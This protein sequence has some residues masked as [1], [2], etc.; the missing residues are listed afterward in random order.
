MKTTKRSILFAL[1]T[2]GAALALAA[3][4]ALAQ[5]SHGDDK[6]AQPG[7]KDD[8]HSHGPAA[9]APDTYA[10]AVA[11]MAS[12]AKE[13]EE[14]LNKGD[15]DAAHDEGD[16]IAAIARSLGALALK[17]D[18]GVDK[19]KVKEINNAGKRI[20]FLKGPVTRVVS[21]RSLLAVHI[22]AGMLGPILGVLHSG[23]RFES[24]LGIALTA[25]MLIVAVSG[26]VGRYLMGRLSTDTR[27]QQQMLAGM[28][29]AYERTAG[30]LAKEPDAAAALRP[31]AG[32]FSRLAAPFFVADPAAG[33][34]RPPG[35]RERAI[36]LS[37][38]MADLEY[39]IKSHEVV[40]D[41]FGRWLACH[42]VIAIV[43]YALLAIH[44]WSAWYFGIRW[45]P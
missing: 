8:G 24:P 19:A 14:A 43:L 45:L 1:F 13:V 38:S 11:E 21:M 7:H 12:R 16:A 23:H 29:V 33:A 10:K 42:I 44:V 37:E 39:A 17:P 26:F 22:Y 3:P 40:K 30:E 25:M 18:S 27:E 41:A 31:F 5:H 20:P 15:L 36:R 35:V 32:F 2:A 4:S 6:K 28:R 34:G 9:K